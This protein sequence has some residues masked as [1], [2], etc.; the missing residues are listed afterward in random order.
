MGPL[1]PPGPWTSASLL[2]Q[3]RDVTIASVGVDSGPW[4]A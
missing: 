4:L 1:R 3:R 2:A